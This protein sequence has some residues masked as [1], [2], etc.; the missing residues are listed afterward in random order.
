MA[1]ELTV[2]YSPNFPSP[3]AYTCMVHQNFLPPNIS[4]VWYGFSQIQSQ[5]KYSHEIT[6]T[7]YIVHEEGCIVAL[8]SLNCFELADHAI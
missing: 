6:S 7:Y 4:C 1:Y 8:I 3:I 2:A 5:M